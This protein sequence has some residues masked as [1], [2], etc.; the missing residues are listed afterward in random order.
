MRLCTILFNGTPT[1]AAREGDLLRPIGAG[2]L[3]AAIARDP[4]PARWSLGDP[5]RSDGGAAALAPLLPG[6][7]VAIGLNYRDHVRETGLDVPGA[8]LVFAKFPSSVIGPR[9][10]IVLPAIAPDQVDWEVE[11]AVVIGRRMRKVTVER[12][13]DHVFGYTVANDVSARDVQF[14][15]VQWTRGKSFDTFC[16]IGPEIV[17]ADEL[18]PPQTLALTTRVNGETVQ[19][20]HTGEMI[21]SVAEILSYCSSAF[22]LQ[23][24][25][26]VLTGTPWGCGGFMDP[27]RFLASGDLL[28]S[29]IA[30][31]GTLRNRVVSATTGPS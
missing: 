2:S 25:D 7:I 11:L 23:P 5:V 31:I 24:G 8:P 10:D 1:P 22:M 20:S 18:P 26:L 19:D 3:V 4:D 27:P 6:K 17:T 12:A 14:G 9:D 28:E 21:F 15:D 30:G 16:P 29:E 13:L